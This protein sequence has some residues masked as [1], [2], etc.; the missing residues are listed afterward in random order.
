MRNFC[1]KGIAWLLLLCVALTLGGTVNVKATDYSQYSTKAVGW[2]L[3]LNRNHTTPGGRYPYSGFQLRNY[4]ALYVGDTQKKVI[5]LTFDCGYE[6]GYTAQIL[7]TL[8]KY[9]VK[10]V[11][12][13]TKHYIESSANL[14]KR[15]KQEGHLV[16]N[17]TCSHAQISS[18][19]VERLRSEILGLEK[20]MKE[21]TG[22]NIDKFVRPPEGKY[23]AK[24]LK[25]LQDMGYTTVFWS[26]AWFDYDV[27]HQ[28]SVSSVVDKFRTYHHKGMI[29]LIH[30]ISSADT[31]ALPQIIEYMRSQNYTFERLD[32]FTKKNATITI[33]VSNHTYN[34]KIPKIVVTTNSDG[35]IAYT[36]YNSQHKK[37]TKPIHAG[38]YYLRAS[39][40][41]TN[42]YKAAEKE[43]KFRIR[44]APSKVHVKV[45]AKV[46]EG[47]KLKISVTTNNKKGKVTY[48]Y[49]NSKGNKITKPKKAGKYFVMVKISATDD[50]TYVTSKKKS[51]QI[52]PKKVDK[53]EGKENP[54][55][56]ETPE[57]NETPETNKDAETNVNPEDS[58][59]SETNE[60]PETNET[61]E[62]QTI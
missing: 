19:S 35:K 50:Y 3:G 33:K 58:E 21:K 56:R 1:K 55:D 43:A 4:N 14:V 36:I 38:I 23:S 31:K 34:G 48:R 54:Q 62:N 25:V 29:P 6:N 37:V 44:K 10:A 24:A 18:L 40:E 2:G 22:Y 57:V 15:M 61:L 11:F 53:M 46:R 12:F 16:A 39:V 7:D 26:L 45:S 52:L 17:H 51:F 28:P 5:Y 41:T 47:S 30:N 42:Q 27:N 20:V 32:D 8:K 49:Y 60:T 9:H 13:V 59:T